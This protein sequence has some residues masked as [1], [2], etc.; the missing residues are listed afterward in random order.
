MYVCMYVCP[1][2]PH[3]FF[4]RFT[5]NRYQNFPI[6]SALN[7]SDQVFLFYP[8]G[9]QPG[10]KISVFFSFSDLHAFVCV[11]SIFAILQK[12]RGGQDGQEMF[13]HIFT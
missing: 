11:E 10:M 8:P 3:S 4:Y 7:L 9:G 6:F 1:R 13:C 12:D 5:P 2:T